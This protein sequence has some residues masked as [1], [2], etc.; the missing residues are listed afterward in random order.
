VRLA[1]L[2]SGFANSKIIEFGHI[3][4]QNKGI[5]LSNNIKYSPWKN[6]ALEKSYT[7]FSERI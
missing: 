1:Q 2:Q 5:V 7:Y 3:I 4:Y 6:I